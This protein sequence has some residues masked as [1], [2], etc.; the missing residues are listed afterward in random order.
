MP[1]TRFLPKMK[2]TI[3]TMT[4]PKSMK[5]GGAPM[6]DA[7]AIHTI[8]KT[9]AMAATIMGISLLCAMRDGWYVT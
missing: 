1:L 4:V 5:N 3:R 2:T 7:V 6:L 8:E 9:T